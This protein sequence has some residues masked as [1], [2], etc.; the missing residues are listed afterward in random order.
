MPDIVLDYHRLKTP[1]DHPDS[2]V[3]TPKVV[4]RS[5]TPDKLDAE[6]FG[7]T[8]PWFISSTYYDVLHHHNPSSDHT[9]TLLNRVIDNVAYV[10]VMRDGMRMYVRNQYPTWNSGYTHEMHTP[11]TTS[12]HY[13]V[14]WSAGSPT[15][16][17]YES[18]DLSD[19]HYSYGISVLGSSFKCYRAWVDL[20]NVSAQTP[21]FTVTDTSYASGYYGI[22]F[23]R[24]GHQHY[25]TVMIYLTAFSKG[26]QALATIEVETVKDGMC[27]PLLSRNLVDVETV[28]G[29]PDFLKREKKKYSMLSA[30]GF[31]DEEIELLLG[32]IPQRYVDLD[33]VTWGAFEFSEKSPTNIVT[34]FSDNP[35]FSG[36]VERQMEFARSRGLRVLKPPRDYGEAVNQYN[37]LRKGFKHWLA[38]KDNYAYQVLGW[39]VLDLFQNADFYYGELLEHKAHYDQLKLAPDWEIS[40]RLEVLCEELSRVS[41]LVDERDRHLGKVKEVLRRGW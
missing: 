8:F 33:A 15:R 41:V 10:V 32:Y 13:L 14:R 3:T 34:V 28:M 30:R 21:A 22:G 29:A 1:I 27:E 12:D 35:Y 17:A 20:K 5:I 24:G 11:A 36:A 39:E 2:S 6:V 4:D 31:S 7:R 23:V 37:A 40:S 9:V 26:I 38:G 16:I 18:V 19:Y 25:S